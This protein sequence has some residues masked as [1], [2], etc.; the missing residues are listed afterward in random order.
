MQNRIHKYKAWHITAKLMLYG[1]P[2]EVFQWVEDGQPVIPLQFT[3]LHDKNGKEIYE[4]D[5]IQHVNYCGQYNTL[6]Q[7]R[8]ERKYKSVV[9]W[10]NES[11]VHV[12]LQNTP[13]M[14]KGSGYGFY[15]GVYE[16]IGNIYENPELIK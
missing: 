13:T 3:G 15:D 9:E 16:I 8:T 7:S 10:G 14:S 11:W 2:K 4:G 5:V 12:M 6:T 1:T